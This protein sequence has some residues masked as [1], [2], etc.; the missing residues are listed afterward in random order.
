RRYQQEGDAFIPGYLKLLSY[1]GSKSP[2]EALAERDIDIRDAAFWQ[3]GFEVVKD[4]IDE[5]QSIELPS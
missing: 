1:G 5:L 4:M 2:A 3:G